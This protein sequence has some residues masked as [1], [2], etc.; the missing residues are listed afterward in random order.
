LA[1]E[2]RQALDAE[3]AGVLR[4]GVALQERERDRAVERAEQTDRRGPEPFELGAQLVAQPNPGLHQILSAAAQRPQRLGLVTVGLEHAKAM[5]VGSGELAQHERVEPV[6]LAARDPKPGPGGSDLVGMQGQHPQTGVQQP[7]NQ[8]PVRAL[9]RDQLH[10]QAH[11]R[12]A[13]R[14]QPCL[15][16]RERGRQQLLARLVLHEHVVLLRRP[17]DARVTSHVY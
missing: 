13:Q 2:R 11:Q 17:V 16:V 1:K 10:L 14:P 7:L 4:A 8:Q 6:G 5:A 12:A 3:R 9:D 15:V